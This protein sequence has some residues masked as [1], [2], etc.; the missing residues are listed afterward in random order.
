V[1]LYEAPTYTGGNLLTGIVNANRNHTREPVTT[2]RDGVTL[3]VSDNGTRLS[4]DIVGSGGTPARV[5]GGAGG[6]ENEFVLKSNTEYLLL[7]TNLSSTA[8]VLSA[9]LFWYEEAF[10]T[11]IN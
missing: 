11:P 10:P 3:S 6:N 5:A 4:A 9:D 2:L 1:E 7:I 8:T